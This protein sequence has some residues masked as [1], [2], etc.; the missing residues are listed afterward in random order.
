MSR[1]S[2]RTNGDV[3]RDF[4]SVA[5]LLEEP[6]LAQLYAY[7]TREEEA[8]VQELMDGL[9]LAQG[10]AYAYVNRLVDAGV[11]EVTT[12]EQPRTYVA[13][14]IDLTVTAADGAREYTITPALI[15][16]VG[17][18]ATDGDIDTYIDRHGIAGLATALT[19]TVDRERGEVTHRLMARDLDISALAAEI[20]LQALRPVVNEHFDIEEAGVSV[21]DIEGVD[22]DIAG[23]DA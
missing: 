12:D 19:Y 23:D 18:R 13:R 15:D 20:I 7:I 3:I 11:L 6:Q 16:A 17:R 4:L 5:D 10:T 8:T 9:D 14:D 1:T 22:R 21:A 2:N